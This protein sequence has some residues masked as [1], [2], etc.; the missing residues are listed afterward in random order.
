MML[1]PRVLS[2]DL[3]FRRQL[4]QHLVLTLDSA[5][6]TSGRPKLQAHEANSSVAEKLMTGHGTDQ[7]WRLVPKISAVGV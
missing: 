1:P 5:Y 6:D 2:L 3:L 4:D 7:L